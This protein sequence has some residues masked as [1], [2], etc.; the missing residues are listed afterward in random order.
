VELQVPENK[1]VPSQ[2]HIRAR[3]SSLSVPGSQPRF[4][5]KA[6]QSSADQVVFDLEDS[7]APTAKA[8]ARDQVIS[9]LRT[10]AFARKLRSV[11]VNGCDTAWCYE[12]IVAIMEGAGDRIDSLVVPKVE[13]ADEVNFVD[14]LLDQIERKLNLVRPISLELLIESARGFENIGLIAAASP[15]NQALIFGPADL[16]ASLRI[17]ELTIGGQP[18][19]AGDYQ[20]YF[21]ARLL[22]ASRAHGLQAVDGPYAHIHDA[23]GLRV[24]AEKAARLGF[25]GKWAVHPAQI[26]VLNEVF[27]PRQ[28]DFDKARAILKAYGRATGVEKVGAVMLGDEMIDEASRKM[29]LVMVARGRSAGMKARPWPRSSGRRGDQPGN[30]R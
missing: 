25:D 3:R 22:M 5:S 28:E 15:R 8:K 12:D 18:G 1:T 27:S 9:A 21:L 29:A 13:G 16:A 24:S 23:D 19:N 2:P 11:R 14:S 6:D 4:H 10:Y 26:E 7:V 30:K 17:P 20:D